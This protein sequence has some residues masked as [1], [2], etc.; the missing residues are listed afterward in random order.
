LVNRSFSNT[1]QAVS[2]EKMARPKGFCH[3]KKHHGQHSAGE[4]RRKAK[5]G[6]QKEARAKLRSYDVLEDRV[7]EMRGQIANYE[8]QIAASTSVVL[9]ELVLENDELK[10]KVVELVR[11]KSELENDHLQAIYGSGVPY[12]SFDDDADE[13]DNDAQRQQKVAHVR[14]FLSCLG[15]QDPE[16]LKC[17][18][19]C[20]ARKNRATI[21]RVL[22]D[23]KIASVVQQNADKLMKSKGVVDRNARASAV[24]RLRVNV[25]VRCCC[26]ASLEQP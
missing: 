19:V 15:D 18:V 24:L 7:E 9:P 6:K 21:D 26:D 1:S 4:L 23:P 14:K 8:L 5:Q 22:S 3:R 17:V 12:I 13:P 25:G 11:E 10:K 2:R 20:E 16:L